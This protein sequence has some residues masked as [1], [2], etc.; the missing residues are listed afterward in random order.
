MQDEEKAASMGLDVLEV[1]G[2]E[3]A[4]VELHGSVPDCIHEGWKY[5][6]EELVR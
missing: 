6:M 5:V 1:S 3:Y 2:M 4:I